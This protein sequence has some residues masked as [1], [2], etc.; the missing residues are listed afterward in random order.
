M[1]HATRT[2]LFILTVLGAA[3]AQEKEATKPAP[4]KPDSESS[5]KPEPAPVVRAH[6]VTIQG[7]ILHY[8][9]TA[10]RMPIRNAAGDTEAQMFYTAYTLD[11]VTDPSR[12]R[13]V[14]AF[15][16]GPGSS[17]VWLQ[18]GAIG[19]QRVKLNDDGSLPAP[20]YRLVPNEG[21]WLDD[22]D[23]VFIHPVGTGYSPA[24]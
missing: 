5:A 22:A 3:A 20:P 1:R 23:L 21:T 10:G 19:P 6:E 9:T 14:F 8:K 7:K 2:L 12:R 18:M 11:G 24:P 13:L 17:S 15:H 4:P 16:G